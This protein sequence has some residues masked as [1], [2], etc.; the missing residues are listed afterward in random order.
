MRALH[1]EHDAQAALALLDEHA[2]RFSAGVLRS[3]AGVLRTEALLRLGRNDQALA[4]L[5]AMPLLDLPNRTEHLVV[6]GEL[7]A[8]HGRWR[9]ALG[10]FDA[11]LL[12]QPAVVGTRSEVHQRALWG[13]ASA[14]SRLGDPQ[15][16]RV[17]LDHYLLQY[18]NGRFARSAAE[19]KG[20]SP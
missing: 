6:R 11:A 8:A 7:R 3:E 12:G 10:D 9:E 20:T 17:D 5:D 2:R 19:L 18:P 4:L 14:R 1:G 16:A 13:R 15:G